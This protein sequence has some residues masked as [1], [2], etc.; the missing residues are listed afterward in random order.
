M[1]D[2]CVRLRT[3][4]VQAVLTVGK[5]VLRE[6]LDPGGDCVPRYCTVRSKLGTVEPPGP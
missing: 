2:Q 3:W 1:G 5:V 6:G 4:G